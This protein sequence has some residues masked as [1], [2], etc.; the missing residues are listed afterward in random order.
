MKLLL[1]SD[2]HLRRQAPQSRKDDFYQT[3]IEKMVFLCKLYQS[4][5][6]TAWL[7]AGDLFHTP[8]PS[9][10][11]LVSY[12]YLLRAYR[13]HLYTVLGQ[14]D[15]VMHSLATVGRCAT[16]LLQAAE[17]ATILTPSPYTLFENLGEDV[18]VAGAHWGL[19]AP[20][21]PYPRAESCYQILVAHA[22]VGDRPLYP[23][24]TPVHPL[25]YITDHPGYDLILV[26]DYHY[27]FQVQAQGTT[28]LNTGCLVRLTNSVGDR[29][30]HPKAAVV[31]TG[32][33][34]IVWYDIPHAPVA[35]VFRDPEVTD[36]QDDEVLHNIM[37]FAAKLQ[38]SDTSGV[39]F[40]CNLL[41]YCR[42]QNV[43]P[44]ILA[45]VTEGME[46]VGVE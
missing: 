18:Y 7:Q 11:L 34:E 21:V 16:A 12:I 3:Q 10:E 2:L 27:T 37:A 43:D 38:Q 14:H 5:G 45:L 35:E 19:E 46:A 9:R 41:Q 33:R 13:V 23:G 29:E 15:V 30:H 6:C 20:E 8:D 22:P 25:K 1:T 24:D 36:K 4:T 26:G 40:R 32:T 39:D 17:V 28:L 42:E 44:G 31:D